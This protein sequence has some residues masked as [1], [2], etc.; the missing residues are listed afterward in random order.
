MGGALI[1]LG[2][3]DVGGGL[4]IQPRSIRTS[5]RSRRWAASRT[6][7]G[8]THPRDRQLGGQALVAPDCGLGEISQRGPSP[9]AGRLR[10][11][12]GPAVEHQRQADDDLVSTLLRGQSLD[13]GAVMFW[14]RTMKRGQWPDLT[15]C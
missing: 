9:L 14:S 5:S 7:A 4:A 6:P 2:L 3:K 12:A 1:E 8:L 11:L 13:G 10:L 15:G